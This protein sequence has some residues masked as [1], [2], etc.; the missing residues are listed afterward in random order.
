MRTIEEIQNELKSKQECYDILVK[1]ATKKGD[2]LPNG[3]SAM[4]YQLKYCRQIQQ[5]RWELEQANA[6][7]DD[8]VIALARGEEYLTDEEKEQR[9]VHE[10]DVR[11]LLNPDGD[12]P[13]PNDVKEIAG[14]SI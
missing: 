1:Y 13:I 12:I 14:S 6:L 5:L 8:E 9:K 3:M 7:S 11:R 4:D 2:E 10:R